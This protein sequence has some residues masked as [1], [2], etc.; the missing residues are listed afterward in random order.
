MADEYY[1]PNIWGRS[2]L[3]AAEDILG[4]KGVNA[5][6]NLAGLEQ[7]INNYPPDNIKKEF[8]DIINIVLLALVW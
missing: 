6:L 7:Y 2:I 3:T 5:L 4:E 8:P 1:Y